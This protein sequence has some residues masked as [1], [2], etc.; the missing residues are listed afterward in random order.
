MNKKILIFVALA[1]LLVVGVVIQLAVAHSDS[2]SSSLG[3]LPAGA[4]MLARTTP[5]GKPRSFE[6]VLASYKG[7]VVYVDF[8]ASW[9]G[10]CRREMP[11]SAELKEKIKNEN[12]VFLYVSL[13]ESQND[14]KTAV[15]KL[16]I[17]GKHFLPIDVVAADIGEKYQVT[18]IPRYMIV[19]KTGKIVNAD[20]TR[21]G[22]KATLEA[23]QAELN[24]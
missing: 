9:C 11:K 24:K 4:E 18:G 15:K 22:E 20:A 19:D 17:M 10:P 1:C 14:F 3:D 12:L 23:L 8:W 7:K 21:P 16:N 2:D 13:D 6:D 5:D